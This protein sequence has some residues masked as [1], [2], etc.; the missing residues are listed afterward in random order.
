VARASE[1]RKQRGPVYA[2]PSAMNGS[3][4]DWAKNTG[5]AL[6][7][8]GASQGGTRGFVQ[9]NPGLAPINTSNVHFPKE[10]PVAQSSGGARASHS[11]RD[12]HGRQ[13]SSG[14]SGGQRL[15]I[16]KLPQ[17]S[18]SGAEAAPA[19]QR[20]AVPH[21]KAEEVP[22]PQ[23]ARQ[24][25][26]SG[27]PRQPDH[28]PSSRGSMTARPSSKGSWPAQK[29]QIGAPQEQP[30]QEKPQLQLPVTPAKVLKHHIDELTEFEQ[31]EILD[32][33]QIW[34]FG[35]GSQKL[36]GTAAAANNH[37]YDDER[38]DYLIVLHDHIL[39]RY[40][41]MNPLGKGSFGQ[42]VRSY[43][44][45]C[46]SYVALKMIRNKKRFHHQAL[47]EVKILEH[48]RERDV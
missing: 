8:L 21:A 9:R 14:S 11:A 22:P 39:Y 25:R 40:E 31:G 46:N 47:V 19:P 41:V 24:I 38:G 18:Y 20:H 35:A 15:H 27:G 16:G 36:R 10:E 43:D 29:P 30:K 26:S 33:P 23:S 13:G 45:K 3:Q 44:F 6:P 1:R 37:S 4:M 32:F 5:D 17:A 2:G 42:V 7:S 12:P 48:L 28:H 34:T